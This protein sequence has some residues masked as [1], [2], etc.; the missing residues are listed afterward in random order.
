ML[1]G[2]DC[3]SRILRKTLADILLGIGLPTVVLGTCG[4]L[5]TFVVPGLSFAY[6]AAALPILPRST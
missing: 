4:T 1:P 2:L 6:A 5:L 3:A